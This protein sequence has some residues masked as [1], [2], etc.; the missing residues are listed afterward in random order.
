MNEPQAAPK[1]L[2]TKS[3]RFERAPEAFRKQAKAQTEAVRRQYLESM[4]G[5]KPTNEDSP[6]VKADGE[7]M[8]A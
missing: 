8:S 6:V 3:P 2:P 5:Q 1:N 4:L 7:S